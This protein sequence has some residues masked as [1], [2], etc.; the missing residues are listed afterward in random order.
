MNAC[1]LS[2][3]GMDLGACIGSFFTGLL[4]DWLVPLLPF[5][6]WAVGILALGLAYRLAGVPGL[7][8]MAGAIGYILG[9]R[10]VTPE[11]H[12]H[13]SGADAAPVV[14]PKKKIRTIFGKR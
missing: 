2:L 12:E 4:P 8:A 3:S 11:P 6:P 5:W 14:K 9:R 7:A 13:V 1:K 10:S